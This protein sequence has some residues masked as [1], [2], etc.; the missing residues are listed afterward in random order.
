MWSSMAETRLALTVGAPRGAASLRCDAKI[1]KG[2]LISHTD[3]TL[4]RLGDA[5]IRRSEPPRHR[6][7]SNRKA[8]TL[9]SGCHVTSGCK[10]PSVFR[11]PGLRKARC[12]CF[13][14]RP[15]PVRSAKKPS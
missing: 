11:N 1:P 14:H 4:F 5:P 3:E 15:K 10:Q 2:F 8:E 12:S 7:Y 9:R 6:V 13:L